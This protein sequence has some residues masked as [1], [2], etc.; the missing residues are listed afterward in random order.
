MNKFTKIIVVLASVIITPA[1]LFLLTYVIFESG[2]VEYKFDLFRGEEFYVFGK[3]V[4][5]SWFGTFQILVW[6]SFIASIPLGVFFGFKLIKRPDNTPAR[7]RK[8]IPALAGVFILGAPFIGVLSM[9]LLTGPQ[10]TNSPLSPQ[11]QAIKNHLDA[12]KDVNSKDMFGE[13]FMHKAATSS[14]TKVVE[15][16]IEKGANVNAKDNWGN[17]P[18]LLLASQSGSIPEANK[19]IELLIGKGADVN[20]TDNKGMTPLD[21]SKSFRGSPE[22][23][24]LLIRHGGKTG[25]ELETNGAI[26]ENS[27]KVEVP[28]V[29]LHQAARYGDIEVVKTHL[30]VGRKVDS[31]NADGQTPLCRAVQYGQ[32]E[33]IKFLIAEGANVNLRMNFGDTALD[34][35]NASG[36]LGMSIEEQKEVVN[37]LRKHGGKT[38]EELKAAEP[39]VEAAK[40]EPPTAKSPDTS[41]HYAVKAGNIEAVKQHLAA[42]TDVDAKYDNGPTPLH[43]A[44]TNG[45]KEIVELLIAKGADVN[46]WDGNGKTSLHLAASRDHKEIA[47]LLIAKG[48]D[49]NVKE[50]FLGYTP[51]HFAAHDDQKEIAE[52]LISNGADMN[53]KDKYKSAPLHH[54]IEKGQKEIAE[55]L[56]A[57]GA[58]VNAKSDFGRTPLIWAALNGHK[59]IAELLIAKG[60]DVNAKDDDGATPLDWAISLK[61]T[62]TADLIRKHGGKT[63]EELKAEGK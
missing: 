19:T 18:L 63:G 22:A 58:D 14:Q 11:I 9:F 16:L 36:G 62:E 28:S 15:Y 40:P 20:S 21:Y 55:L 10:A 26:T 5:S 25:V 56:I 61:K 29:L 34:Y 35:A 51:L 53:A 37:L 8:L 24:D 3:R 39:V 6:G 45:H 59:E 60:A 42:G 30:Q 43:F 49:V 47:E 7:S 50:G 13:T 41:I 1:I 46:A 54:A 48:A 12:G 31:K 52:L 4:D 38:R 44:A 57:N 27:I 33:M 2:M 17:T 32:K 23:S